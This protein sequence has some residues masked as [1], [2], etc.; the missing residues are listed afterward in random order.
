M[1]RKREF[2][3]ITMFF[4]L[5]G[6]VISTHGKQ[7]MNAGETAVDGVTGP[8]GLVYSS[9][10]GGSGDDYGCAVARDSQNNTIIA[11][12]TYSTDFP[13]TEGAF[14]TSHNGA[15]DVFVSKFAEDGTLLFSTF[16]GG[17]DEETENLGDDSYISHAL[18]IAVDSA[19]NIVIYGRTDSNDFPVTA[20][21]YDT[22]Y[23]G[24]RDLFIVKLSSDGSELLFATYLGGSG[25]EDWHL[26]ATQTLVLDQYDN[27]IV[28]GLASSY[29]FPTTPNAI[30]RTNPGNFIAKLSDDGSTLLY[31]SFVGGS[32]A[33][34]LAIDSEGNMIIA[35]NTGDGEIQPTAGAY[36]TT[37]NGGL[38]DG[39]ILKL[40]ADGSEILWTTLLGGT[41]WNAAAM[42][43]V[44]TA[45]DIYVAGTINVNSQN[46]PTTPG[47]NDTT[48]DGTGDMYIAK[49]SKNG[50]ELLF[51]TLHGGNGY[52][53][54]T[55]MVL[56]SKNSIYFTGTTTSTDYP[57]TPNAA[58]TT[59]SGGQ[60]YTVAKLT[61]DCSFVQ[62]AT[63][64]G[65]SSQ[66][67]AA[68]GFPD[69]SD[70][71]PDQIA[72][73]DIELVDEDNVIVVGTTNS[74]DYPATA[75]AYNST[76]AGGHDAF[77]TQLAWT[78][79]EPPVTT[80]TAPG[81]DVFTGVIS[82]LAVSTPI[83]WSR[84]K[85]KNKEYE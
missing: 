27:I 36:D 72:T 50:D 23:G 63:Y 6:P 68:F 12:I 62:Y 34:S 9:F 16:I 44:D 15:S 47:A 1:K 57:V 71:V 43:T 61:P 2:L 78:P 14:D 59:L 48:L 75:G 49:L 10:I 69:W 55:R 13:V 65:G 40:S 74:T 7:V 21:S 81:F 54:F 79:L 19:D 58:G 11:G 67:I 4:L 18:S 26:Y 46:F 22:I 56:D 42:A 17:S 33:G 77:I 38:H 39:F 20:G 31:S 82:I 30:D 35:G 53:F 8:N 60:D 70:T 45:G 73:G 83:K 3:L 80:T 85:K 24:G 64:L 66:E 29:D 52:D 37:Y 28:T 51:S 41:G 32:C 84:R 5:L 76:N 25:D